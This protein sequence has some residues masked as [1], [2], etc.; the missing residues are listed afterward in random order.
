MDFT[1]LAD[2]Y[3]SIKHNQLHYK[4]NRSTI[5]GKQYARKTYKRMSDPVLILDSSWRL[6]DSS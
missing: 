3:C 4:I 5:L 2:A 1:P 6:V